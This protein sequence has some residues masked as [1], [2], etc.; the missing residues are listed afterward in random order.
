MSFDTNRG[1]CVPY[2]A[3]IRSCE[4]DFVALL[5][6]DTRVDPRWLVELVSTADRHHAAAVASKILDW[7]GE[8]IEF[9]GGLVSFIGHS[10]QVD[11]RAP[12]AGAYGEEALL[13]PCAASALFRRA[14]FL[15][16]GGF[17]ED[18]FAS[19]EDVDLGWRLNLLGHTVVRAPEAVT[20]RRL[21]ETSAPWTVAQRAR[22]LERNALAM[23]YKNYEAETLARVFPA[24][25]ALSLMRGLMLSGLGTLQLGMSS[26]PG[27]VFNA[28]QRLVPH[29]LAL[30]DFCRQLAPL[31]AKRKVIQSRRRR[32]D[33]ELFVLF[34][35][36][37]RLHASSGPYEDIARTLI[38]D[39]GIAEIFASSRTAPARRAV[40]AATE[41]GRDIRAGTN[42]LPTSEPK[43]S[44]VIP[45]ALGA[46]HLRDCLAALREQSYPADRVEVI[47]VDN[48]SAEDPTEE[49]QRGYPGARVIR[50]PAN[51]GFAAGNNLGASAATGDQLIFLND[52]TRAH[53]D[54][55]RELV[56]TARR[57]GAAA[58]ASRILDWSGERID[59]VEGVVNFQGKGFQLHYGA[60]AG[61]VTPE[62]K[63]LLF[64]CGCAMLIDRAVFVDVGTWDED[65]FAYYEDVEL[66]WRLNLL[67]HAVWSAPR[68]VVYHKHHGTSGRWAEPPRIRLYERNSLRM[69]YGLLDTRS[70]ERVLPA[71]LLLAADAA[72]LN[73]RLSRVEESGRRQTWQHVV[74]SIKALL[75]AQGIDKTTPIGQAIKRLGIR[76][77]VRVAR[78]LFVAETSR[79]RRAAYFIERGELPSMFDT[80]FEALPIKAAAMLAGI[81]GFLSDIPGLSRRR[82]D[83]QRRRQTTDQEVLERFGTHWLSPSPAP[84]QTEHDEVH[85]ALVEEFGLAG[86]ISPRT[87]E[88]REEGARARLDPVRSRANGD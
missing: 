15:D 38:R 45:T 65:A 86:V 66:G 47:I 43:V 72:L 81:Y 30:E 21:H 69:L 87:P 33:P 57:R 5:S 64:A 83:L 24:A 67:G 70:L 49:A 35:E 41:P 7:T 13:F 1:V 50:N 60:P 51:L 39:F 59:F 11:A 80:Q 46:T 37:F 18:F 48:G 8:T 56:G 34:G 28:D 68:A 71:A 42:R 20:Y 52:D 6:H 61:S 25:V 27:E 17:D 10:W 2:N 9:V 26:R 40:P 29:L 23:I 77:F 54:W 4:S 55:L 3:A 19:L 74:S 82:V 75:R 85:A 31:K 32:S 76:G 58:V 44:I 73:T 22:L 88:D 53:P 16:A 36:P 79:S 63:P 62:E 84:F 14:A 12:S 78:D